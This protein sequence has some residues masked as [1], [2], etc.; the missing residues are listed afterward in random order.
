MAFYML[1]R[2]GKYDENSFGKAI[3]ETISL[4]GK[5]GSNACVVGGMIGALV[6]KGKIPL[7]MREKIL[8]CDLRLG[9]QQNRPRW[10]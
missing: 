10:L 6:G 7:G 4:G 1:L 2:Y 5:T 8:E 9:S 3:K